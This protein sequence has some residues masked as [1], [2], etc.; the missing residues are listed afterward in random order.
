VDDDKGIH[1]V[2]IR[3][4]KEEEE[5]IAVHYMDEVIEESGGGVP[6]VGFEAWLGIDEMEGNERQEAH[7][8]Q[9]SRRI[10]ATP[11]IG[12]ATRWR[13]PPIQ[14]VRWLPWRDHGR[15]SWRR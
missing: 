9:G 13:T 4:A 15:G 10:G 6:I 8:G 5:T 3:E 12:P 14:G 2:E 11:M 1:V 7:R